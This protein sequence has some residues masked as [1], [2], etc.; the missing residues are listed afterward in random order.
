M[1]FIVSS[2]LIWL[3]LWLTIDQKNLMEIM[4]SLGLKNPC[5]PCLGLL[6]CLLLGC[7][8]PQ[9][10]PSWNPAVVPWEAQ[11]TWMAMCWCSGWQPHPG[12]WLSAYITL[13]PCECA[14]LDI[15]SIAVM[16]SDN[17]WSSCHICDLIIWET[18]SKN[19]LTELTQA[20]EP[21]EK[22]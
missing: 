2:T 1:P 19:C 13:K 10:I 14:I 7:I 12:S 4:L 17:S 11:L 15:Q 22:K 20:K 9:N 3:S 21:G 5:N 16:L 8:L 6:K 18:L